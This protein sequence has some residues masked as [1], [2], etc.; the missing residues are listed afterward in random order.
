MVEETRVTFHSLI[1][2]HDVSPEQCSVSLARLTLSDCQVLAVD[3]AIG[4][5]SVVGR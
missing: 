5:K 4:A 1:L 2:R 3:P